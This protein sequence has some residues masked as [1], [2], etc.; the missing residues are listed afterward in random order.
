[1]KYVAIIFGLV[2]SLAQA[3]EQTVE[4][5]QK[6]IAGLAEEGAL[7]I[8]MAGNKA[9]LQVEVNSDGTYDEISKTFSPDKISNARATSPCSTKFDIQLNSPTVKSGDYTY[10]TKYSYEHIGG[11]T[12]YAFRKETRT[13]TFYH[14][15]SK[16][17]TRTQY[18]FEIDWAKVPAVQKNDYRTS[19][20][21]LDSDGDKVEIFVQSNDYV[22]RLHYALEFLRI[23]CDKK[24]AT[25]F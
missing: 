14:P 8:T 2:A 10:R 15:Q 3:Q 13:E 25:G 17:G 12:D 18:S 20:S 7:T 1:M 19:I 4:G 22:T 6:F 21:L 9:S 24:S 5:A 11:Y 23:K 16:R